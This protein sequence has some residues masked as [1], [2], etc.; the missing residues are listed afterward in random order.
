MV[1]VEARPT[2]EYSRLIDLKLAR[3]VA[4]ESLPLIISRRGHI[5]AS[6]SGRF[7]GPLYT[8]DAAIVGL[9]TLSK[10]QNGELRILREG[11]RNT[12]IEIA[13]HQGKFSNG[14][15]REEPGRY[16]HEIQYDDCDQERLGRIA[17]DGA[18]WVKRVNGHLEGKNYFALDANPLWECLFAEYILTTG[19]LALRERLWSNYEASQ[20]W[21]FEY[22]DRDGDGLIEGGFEEGRSPRNMFWKDADDSLIGES[23]QYPEYPVAPLDVNAFAYR[24]DLLG[25]LLYESRGD[26]KGA[27]KLREKAAWLKKLINKLYWMEDVNLY[28]PALDK[29]K[30]PIRI[31]TSD[32][33]IPLWVGL[34]DEERQ[35]LL[36]NELSREDLFVEGIA[37]RTRSRNSSQ[38][39][40]RSYQN[41]DYWN[42][43][44][45]IAGDAFESLGM[46]DEAKV[47][48]SCIPTIV[49]SNFKEMGVVD[50]DGN[51]YPYVEPDSETGQDIPVACDFQ[52][53]V[54]GG[55]LGRTASIA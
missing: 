22:G 44:A 38:Y 15:T 2:T 34:P 31:E 55:V 36:A 19:D 27:G 28:A 29:Y 25:A 1:M 4:V 54:I 8:R 14:D 40:P 50:D 32:S 18:R 6:G 10:P 35:K 53:W 16:L 11:V 46:H 23:G 5:T 20:R 24:A 21:L 30:S 39:N 12:L 47:F 26:F 42:H 33:V 52:A 7:H 37:L 41:G 43:L 9:Q 48:D 3:E 49:K 17:N 45:L 13:R 51:I